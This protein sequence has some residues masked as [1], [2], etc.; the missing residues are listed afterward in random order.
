LLEVVGNRQWSASTFECA[1]DG[2]PAGVYGA[3]AAG[4]CRGDDASRVRND[5]FVR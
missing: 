5:I 4:S 2:K 1:G 3:F